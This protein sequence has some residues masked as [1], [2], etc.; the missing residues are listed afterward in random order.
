MLLSIRHE[1]V[2]HYT[3]P[4]SYTIQQ[5]RMT[6]RADAHQR[7]QSWHIDTPGKAHPFVDAFGNASHMLTMTVPHSELRIVAAGTVEVAALDR[8]RVADTGNLSPLAF[9]VP[10]RLVQTSPGIAEFAGR[11]LRPRAT[12]RDLVALAEAIRDAVAYC[13]GSTEVTT[14]AADA[15]AL[16]SGVCQDHAHLFLACCHLHDIPARY[17]SGYIDPGDTEH[18]QS[19]AWIDAWVDEPDFTGWVSIDVT[20][21]QYAGSAHCRLAIGRDYESAAPVRG[22]RHGGGLETLTVRVDVTQSLLQQ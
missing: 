4:L 9:T 3:A 21:A 6:P 13:T 10:T 17:V 22:V 15:L 19:H 8:G 7:I 16:G 14:T 1:T 18:A 12:S 2:Y 5:L 20:H 11:H